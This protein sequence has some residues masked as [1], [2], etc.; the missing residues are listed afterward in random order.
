MFSTVRLYQL[1]RIWGAMPH[2]RNYF[3]TP[4]SFFSEGGE[5]NDQ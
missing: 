2:L 3:V 1:I 4:T 5:G